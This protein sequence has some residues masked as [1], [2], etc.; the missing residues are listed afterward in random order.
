MD[1]KN[2]TKQSTNKQKSWYSTT[3]VH[4]I[5]TQNTRTWV[6]RNV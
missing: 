1:T 6:F 3:S 4:G 5:G 2:I